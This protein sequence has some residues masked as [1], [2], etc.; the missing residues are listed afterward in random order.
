MS[1]AATAAMVAATSA[2][3]ASGAQVDA[4]TFAGDLLG[5][6]GIAIMISI[7]LLVWCNR[8]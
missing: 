8:S 4:R 3:R 6:V 5:C 7:V 1:A 2:L